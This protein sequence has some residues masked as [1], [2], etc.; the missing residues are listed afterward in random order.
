MSQGF[1][2]VGL[3]HIHQ[4]TPSGGKGIGRFM[5]NCPKLSIKFDPKAVERNESMT[6]SRAPLR[7]M[8]QTTAASIELVTD[9]FN[10]KNFAL[11]TSARI[12]EVVADTVTTINETFPTG[13]TVGDVLSVTKR[14]INTLVVTDSTGSPKT[15]VLGTNYDVD[16]F[17]GNITILDLTTGAPYVQPFKAAFKQGAVSVL[18]G[19]AVPQTE[20][21]LGLNGIN[22][23]TG[24]KGVL[25]AY[26]CRLDP[27]QVIDFINNEYQ[28]FA[29][30]GA[31]LLDTTKLANAVGGQ[32]FQFAVPST[33]E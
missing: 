17:S 24:Q 14:N 20:L 4:R 22:A 12:D 18:S 11:A 3:V 5:G 13:A 26:R 16:L 23:D 27:A 25:D 8:T 29:I 21:W 31:L 28:D 2:G 32:Y 19:L 9:E 6:T 15:L 10:K 30:N 7:R 33:I 1:S